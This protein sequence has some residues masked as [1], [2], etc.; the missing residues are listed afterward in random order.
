MLNLKVYKLVNTDTNL[1]QV[2]TLNFMRSL[3]Y[4]AQ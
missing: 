3:R 1:Y 2:K 4:D